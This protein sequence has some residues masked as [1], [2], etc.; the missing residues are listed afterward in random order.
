MPGVRIWGLAAIG[1]VAAVASLL[2]P[3]SAHVADVRVAIWAWQLGLMVPLYAIGVGA[4]ALRPAHA[5]ARWLAAA[6]AWVAIATASTRTV[7]LAT[8][9]ATTPGLLVANLLQVFTMLAAAAAL[10]SVLIAFPDERYRYVWQRRLVRSVWAVPIT[11]TVL[12]GLAQPTVRSG[13]VA[14]PRDL[15]TNPA[16]M[17]V[18]E[19][20]AW[21]AETVVDGRSVLWVVGGVALAYRWQRSTSTVRQQL[22]WPLTAAALFALLAGLFVFL[23]HL[24]LID[25]RL[26]R[27]PQFNGWVPGVP[28]VA[29]SMLVAL[30]RHRLIEV[31][32]W[33]RRMLLF[34][35]LSVVIAAGYLSLAGAVGLAAGQRAS[36]GIAVLVTLAAIVLFE[37]PRRRIEAAARRWLAGGRIPGDELLRRVGDVLGD[38]RDTG[39]LG[40]ALVATMVDGLELEWARVTLH[41]DDDGPSLPLAA[42]GIGPHADAV[43]ELAVPLA[44][45][46]TT[47]GLLECGKKRTGELSRDDVQLIVTVARQAALAVTNAGLAAQLES[48][49]DE[50]AR[51]ADELAASRDRL[52][53]AQ[54]AERRRIERDIHDGVQQDVIAAIARIRLARNQLERDP[55]LAS[56]T[57]VDL[58][59]HATATLQRLRE[60]S[61]GIHPLALTHH[62]IV[63]ALEAQIAR[64]PLEV[65]VDASPVAR[66]I[67]YREDIEAAAYFVAAEGLTNVIKHAGTDTATIRLAAHDGHLL[68]EV[69][70]AGRGA[71]PTSLRTGSGLLGLTDRVESLRGELEVDSAPGAGTTLRARLPAH[72]SVTAHD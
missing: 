60:L 70:D 39:R 13:S 19:P 68:V 63:A 56:R 62:G 33:L 31:D 21:V 40:Q 58:Q 37:P 69:V 45:A 61:R 23:A 20:L 24:G 50:L 38:T 44:H 43:P 15:D 71:D 28:L 46:G 30:L 47:I 59:E 35:G 14:L 41:A 27:L 57:L 42:V 1:L 4:L 52:V 64:L 49:L 22:S 48:R 16:A 65:T 32:L 67:R 25:P 10:T 55:T 9:D 72:R 2:T 34:G 8:V 11:T 54:M 51:Q 53:Q 17:D 29:A 5:T 6:G 18:L 26:H 36:A 7:A 12:W 66:Q 3:A